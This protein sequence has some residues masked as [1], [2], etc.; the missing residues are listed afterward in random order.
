MTFIILYSVL[1]LF[2]HNYPHCSVGKDD[3]R[4]G[5]MFSHSSKRKADLDKKKLKKEIEQRK[6]FKP[7]RQVQ[8]KRLEE[9]LTTAINSSNKGFSMLQKMGYIPG[10]SLGKQSRSSLDSCEKC[11]K[12]MHASMHHLYT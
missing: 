3:V 2:N 5:L 1:H 9:G 11:I 7:L 10:T 8:Q 4:P 12:V 6:K